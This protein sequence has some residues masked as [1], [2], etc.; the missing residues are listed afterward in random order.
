MV[1]VKE[2][3]LDGDSLTF[4]TLGH[5]LDV[6]GPDRLVDRVDIVDGKVC[7]WPWD[8][9]EVWDASSPHSLNAFVIKLQQ[10]SSDEAR[11][12]PMSFGQLRAW[13]NER[14]HIDAYEM[15]IA[16]VVRTGDGHD[17]HVKFKVEEMRYADV[18]ER[19]VG[20]VYVVGGDQLTQ[21]PDVVVDET[22]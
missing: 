7:V 11:H 10:I 19:H 12:V 6:L 20:V 13:M 9:G 3:K 18:G 14:S 22:R 2:V 16:L 8:G 5:A 21:L 17:R 1:D 4:K 15:Q